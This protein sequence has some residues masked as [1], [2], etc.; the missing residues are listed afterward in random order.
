MTVILDFYDQ[1]SI[2]VAIK[3]QQTATYGDFRSPIRD[4]FQ[5]M[6]IVLR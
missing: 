4:S 6:P 3:P 5:N 2:D 1:N